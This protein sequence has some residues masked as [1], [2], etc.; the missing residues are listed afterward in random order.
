M[1][2][3]FSIDQYEPDTNTVEEITGL[4][5]ASTYS[6]AINQI[7]SDYGDAYVDSLAIEKIETE[8]NCLEFKEIMQHCSE[9][10]GT[11]IDPKILESLVIA[12]KN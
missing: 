4:L 5:T 10:V 12:A 7:T 1:W 6:D 9:D 8:F 2:Y 11:G 3:K